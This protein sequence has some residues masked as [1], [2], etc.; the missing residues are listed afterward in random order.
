[1]SALVL[2]RKEAKRASMEPAEIRVRLIGPRNARTRA[3]ERRLRNAGTS[4]ELRRP[5]DDGLIEFS[6]GDV[7]LLFLMMDSPNIRGELEQIK[8]WRE[9]GV[10]F[11]II[12]VAPAEKA[13]V[14]LDAGADD[15]IGP[16]VATR[17]LEARIRARIRRGARPRILR[18]HDLQ[19]DIQGRTVTRSGLPI[20]LTPRE[21][22]IL[23]MLASHR[24]RVVTR[25]M[26]WQRL[27]NGADRYASNVVD[28]YIRYLRRKI[29]DGFSPSLILTAWGRG[30]MLRGEDDGASS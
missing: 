24:G 19:I 23:E 7:D 2:P 6:S 20:R 11:P 28:V 17:E 1:M 9:M 12:A 8:S 25:F 27:Y 29:D 21:F 18:I 3:F 26:I 5:S 10:S 14:C 22:A 16:S 4:V 15:C 13:A 30:Y